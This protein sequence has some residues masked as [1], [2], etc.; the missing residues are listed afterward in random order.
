LNPPLYAEDFFLKVFA[1]KLDGLRN[2]LILGQYKRPPS[3]DEAMARND[4]Q[5]KQKKI[6]NYRKN[7]YISTM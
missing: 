7:F 3:R 6:R 2:Y 5:K 1:Q 4:A